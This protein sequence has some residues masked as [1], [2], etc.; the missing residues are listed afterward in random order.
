MKFAT[1]SDGSLD[2][3][4]LIVSRDLQ[5][6]LAQNRLTLHLQGKWFPDGTLAGAEALTR[7]HDPVRGHVSPVDFIP[8]AEDSGLIIPLGRWVIERIGRRVDGPTGGGQ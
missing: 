3:R 1:L 5:R 2:G 7:W 6:A 4:L 8:V